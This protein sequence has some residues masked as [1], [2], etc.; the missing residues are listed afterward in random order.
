MIKKHLFLSG[1][2]RCGKSALIREALGGQ[3]AMA[4]GFVTE[5]LLSPEGALLGC[6]LLPAAAAGGVEGFEPLRF[7]DH[8]VKPPKTDNEV[9][10]VQGVRLLREAA[11]YPFSVLD[12]FGGFELILP[13]FR[14]ALAE[15]L[16]SDQP[17]IGVLKTPE[18]AEA[19]RRALGLGPRY[20]AYVR[21][22]HEAL[23][24]D[25][26]TLVLPV[27]GGQDDAARRIVAQW[28][29]DHLG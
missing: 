10:R 8:T 29:K 26:D 18:E 28:G 16:S 23:A 9:F 3:F 25:G 2:P 6:A 13:Q 1:P 7:L 27:S 11:W 5:N 12:A 15:L 17:C 24:A 4:G 20:T 14:Q 19:L 21:R 22:L